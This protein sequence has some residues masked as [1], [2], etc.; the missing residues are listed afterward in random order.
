MFSSLT[1]TKMGSTVASMAGCGPSLEVDHVSYIC[2][3]TPN[4]FQRLYR[5]Y[6]EHDATNDRVSRNSTGV[7]LDS[8]EFHV[9][10]FGD[11]TSRGNKAALVLQMP[12]KYWGF[13]D[14]PVAQGQHWMV[15]SYECCYFFID[16]DCAQC[17]TGDSRDGFLVQ[18]SQQLYNDISNLFD[19]R[20]SVPA[21]VQI[22]PD[23]QKLSDI[24]VVME[25][26]VIAPWHCFRHNS[27]SFAWTKHS[28]N[29]SYSTRAPGDVTLAFPSGLKT[30][31]DETMDDGATTA[32]ESGE[33]VGKQYVFSFFSVK[34]INMQ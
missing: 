4:N 32:I 23:L 19:V 25:D 29:P 8:D 3:Y 16:P 2:N 24:R 11:N 15:P 30:G 28:N 13:I 7:F 1:Y 33:K 14:N 27:R 22:N 12:K 34:S 5:L 6:R 17:H 20:W 31:D 26:T 21:Y 9:E 10:Y 18:I